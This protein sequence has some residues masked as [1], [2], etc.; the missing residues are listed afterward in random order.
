MAPCSKLLSRSNGNR[1]S[2]NSQ[3]IWLTLSQEATHSIQ[4]WR[5]NVRFTAFTRDH[6]L[7]AKRNLS[8]WV[9]KRTFTLTF[10]SKGWIVSIQNPSGEVLNLTLQGIIIFGDSALEDLNKTKWGHLHLPSP[11]LT[12]SIRKE[13]VRTQTTHR[14]WGNQIIT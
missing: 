3:R 7:A 4:V 13:E 8:V 11:N 9:K 6:D 5:A 12:G 14:V 1:H 10:S 2:T